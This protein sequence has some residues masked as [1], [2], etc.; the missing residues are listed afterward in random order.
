MPQRLI[1]PEA[2]CTQALFG[3]PGLQGEE[4]L[5]HALADEMNKV[6]SGVAVNQ[7]LMIGRKKWEQ[8]LPRGSSWDCRLVGCPG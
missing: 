4:T 7:V 5:S 3:D 2:S 8:S 6:V 1:L